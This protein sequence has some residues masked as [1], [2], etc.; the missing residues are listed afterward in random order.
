MM[1]DVIDGFVRPYGLRATRFSG[2]D[3][4]HIKRTIDLGIPVLVLQWLRGSGTGKN[5][6]GEI[7]HFRTVRGYDNKSGI[8]WIDDPLLGPNVVISYRDFKT[9]W[10][11]YNNQFIPVY[12]TNMTAALERAI[13]TRIPR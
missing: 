5:F 2:G 12:P 1:A 7:P 6:V 9:L 11:V 8:F 10:G 4:E 3:L 13:G